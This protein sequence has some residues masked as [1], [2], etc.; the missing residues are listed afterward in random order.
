MSE[1]IIVKRKIRRLYL[2]RK[3]CDSTHAFEDFMKYQTYKEYIFEKLGVK[4]IWSPEEGEEV[5]VTM[6]NGK[7]YIY[8]E[9]ELYNPSEWATFDEEDELEGK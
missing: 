9:D 6:E 3:A 5:Y 2:F 4:D 1:R 8:C 7:K